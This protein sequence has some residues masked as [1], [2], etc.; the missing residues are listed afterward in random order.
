VEFSRWHRRKSYT[1][2]EVASGLSRAI[3]LV[4]LAFL[5]LQGARAQN[6]QANSTGSC[7]IGT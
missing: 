5:S 6:T 2:S 4:I 3:G 7:H 1:G